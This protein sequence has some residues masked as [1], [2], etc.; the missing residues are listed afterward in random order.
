MRRRMRI[1]QAFGPGRDRSVLFFVLVCYTPFIPQGTLGPR[2]RPAWA[3]PGHSLDWV[4][5][6]G[7]HGFCTRSL[8][9]STFFILGQI[10]KK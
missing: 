10:V 1:R 5:G 7:G 2:S 9:K 4:K 6:P 8:L 3:R